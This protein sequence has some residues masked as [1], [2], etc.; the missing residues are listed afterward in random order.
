M[1][2]NENKV[3]W[4]DYKQ[5]E[6]ELDEM[7]IKYATATTASVRMLCACAIE[8]YRKTLSL[9]K[10][11]LNKQQEGKVKNNNPIRRFFSNI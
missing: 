10:A 11:S 7:Y 1:M 6:K 2:C 5:V 8:E 3:T 4:E 9:M